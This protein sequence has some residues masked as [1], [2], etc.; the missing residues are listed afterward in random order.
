MK[1]IDR[2]AE[3]LK[4]VEVPRVDP[5]AKHF[6]WRKTYRDA[7]VSAVEE[8]VT[9]EGLPVITND[10]HNALIRLINLNVFP[11]DGTNNYIARVQNP[12]LYSGERFR[13]TKLKKPSMY[14]FHKDD[15]QLNSLVLSITGIN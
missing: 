4:D 6:A 14:V 3:I 12:A 7:I 9:N 10:I 1:L 13:V 5:R 2:L 8:Y 11:N 15:D